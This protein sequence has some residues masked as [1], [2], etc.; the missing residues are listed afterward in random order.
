MRVVCGGVGLAFHAARRDADHFLD[1]RTLTDSLT[2]EDGRSRDYA[3][4][5]LCSHGV[6]K[7][8]A[9]LR[10]G[11][12]RGPRFEELFLAVDQR[13]DIVWSEFDTVPVSDRVGGAGLDA[14]AAKDAARIINIVD[15]RIA[16]TGRDALGFDIFRGLDID[17]IRGAGGGAEKAGYAL[18]QSIVVAL[19][20]VD[21]AI[22]R[23]DT[24]RDV[25]EAFRG[26]LP[27]H[28]S[29]SDAESFEER[30]ECLADLSYD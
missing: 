28:R 18:L 23:L 29:Q 19:K 12:T 25:G 20:D 13:V 1:Q 2:L 3:A 22:A 9:I 8:A 4:L 5:K 16:L 7:L 11:I 15:S 17:T 27:E 30:H 24:R 14:V 10:R 6:A 26:S 21:S